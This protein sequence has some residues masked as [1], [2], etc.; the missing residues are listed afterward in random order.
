M[1]H[2]SIHS[3]VE[4]RAL[5]FLT[6]FNASFLFHKD[7]PDGNL[8]KYGTGEDLEDVPF[9]NVWSI[10]LQD[11]RGTKRPIRDA[12]F[13]QL[14]LFPH[15]R[16]LFLTPCDEITDEGLATISRLVHLDHLEIGDGKITDAGLALLAPLQGLERLHLLDMPLSD[17]ALPHLYVHAKL[18]YLDVRWTSITPLGVEE[19]KKALPN[20]EVL[21]ED[22]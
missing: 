1:S 22:L 20:C 21:L 18:R 17:A 7:T 16:T 2:Q 9:A 8:S 3:P 5:R 14:L 10:S 13:L 19:L 12:D 4:Q 15:L 11:W 6:A